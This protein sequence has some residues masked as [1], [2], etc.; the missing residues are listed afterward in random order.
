MAQNEKCVEI[1]NFKTVGLGTWT[2]TDKDVVVP[3][4]KS[5]YEVG[6]RLIDTAK[7]Y[8]NEEAIGEFVK[9]VDRETLFITS[10]LWCT[11]HDAVQQACE[12]S[13]K[14]LN[15]SYLDL[16]LIHWPVNL[17]G[18]YDIKKLWRDMESLVEKGLVKYIGI[19][20]FTVSGVKELLS[21]CKIKPAVNQIE[22]HPYNPEKELR[23]FCQDNCI[24]VQS[25]STLGS[26]DKT[27]KLT[28]D[29]EVVRLAHKYS[30]TPTRVLLGYAVGVGCAVIPRSCNKEHQLENFKILSLSEDDLKILDNLEHKAKYILAPDDPNNKH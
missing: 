21:F 2:L 1:N 18:K 29:P 8:D 3:A 15:T 27:P 26:S 13:L 6:Y 16:Y 24:T 20:N 23:K 28:E 22:L 4:L 14:K 25:Y 17:A 7:V 11:D 30:T 19:S 12:T 10:K 9:T 5:A